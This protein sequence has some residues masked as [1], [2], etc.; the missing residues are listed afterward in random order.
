MTAPLHWLGA[1]AAAEAIRAGQLRSEA[2]VEALLARIAGREPVVHAWAHLDREAVLRQARDSDARSAAGTLH[3]VPI[4]WKD[5]ID[6]AGLPTGCGSPIHAGH[7][8]GVDA[9]AVAMS[10]R[11]GALVMGKTV[12]TEFAAS[13]PGATT[14]PWNPAHTPGGS[15]SG[16]AAAVADGMVPLATGTQTGGSVIR[17][18]SFC[19]VVGFKPSFGLINRYGVK[20]LAD[21]FDTVG[22]FARSVD[23][24]ALLVAALT[25]RGD[26]EAIEASRPAHV[27][28]CKVPE[29]NQAEAC[30]HQALEQTAAALSAAGVRVS[31]RELPPGLAA[32]ADAL[33]RIEYFELARALQYEYREHRALLSPAIASRIEQGLAQPPQEYE[34]AL[35]VRERCGAL[36]REFLRDTD[37]LLVPAAPG[38]AP[39]GLQ[40]T[41]KATFNRTWTAL[42]LPAITLPGHRGPQGLPLGVQF[43]AGPRQDARLLAH[44]ACIERC[45]PARSDGGASV[46]ADP[47][48]DFAR[49]GDRAH[50]SAASRPHGDGR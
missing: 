28:L 14:H 15:S 9:G 34:E 1:R 47:G 5:V 29:W 33:P 11:A 40:R 30:M 8:A 7:V 46:A 27:V 41:G 50:P 10:R 25:G 18:A 32:L 3:G 49:A 44:A 39:R 48:P 22:T 13:H 17:P 36:V 4:G 42:G 31:T 19:G 20:Q 23:D 2:L 37:L 26:F 45:L 35:A 38:E 6:C 12:T 43:V 16:S 21:S 24:T